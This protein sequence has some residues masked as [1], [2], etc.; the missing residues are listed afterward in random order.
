MSFY[1]GPRRGGGVQLSTWSEIEIAAG[2][3]V[4]DESAWVEHKQDVPR[5]NKGANKELARDLAS[6]SVDGGTLLIGVVDKSLEVVGVSEPFESLRTR[7]VQVA[8]T[9]I[10]PPLHVDVATIPNPDATHGEHVVVVAVP[11]SGNAPHM[12]DGHYWGRTSEGKRILHDVEV[13]RL[14]NRRAT[15]QRDFEAELRAVAD[16]LDTGR[17]PAP[18]HGQL[19][20]LAAPLTPSATALSDQLATEYPPYVLKESL[21]FIPQW[22]PWTLNVQHHQSHPDG[23][24]IMNDD[25]RRD[26]PAPPESAMDLLLRDDGAV[27]AA[28]NRATFSRNSEGAGPIEMISAGYVLEGAHVLSRLTGFLAD[29]YLANTG[30]YRVGVLVTGI[31]GCY[32]S[33]RFG[34]NGT[35]DLHPYPSDEYLAQTSASTFELLNSPPDVAARLVGRLLRSIGVERTF[36]PYTNGSQIAERNK[37]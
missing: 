26:A 36:V 18:V 25:P 34:I 11:A 20:F 35:W 2:A 16:T 12:V 31:R 22:M 8:A 33:Q 23:I 17:R 4:L 24:L 15:S 6:L 14:M 27:L 5:K 1:I 9:V 19:F 13:E 28:G 32:A 10:S 29:Q 37:S 21:D 7:I 30:Q 3:G